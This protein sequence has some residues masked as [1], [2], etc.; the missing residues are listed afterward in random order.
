MPHSV[1]R[2]ALTLSVFAAV[3]TLLFAP[4]VSAASPSQSALSAKIPGLFQFAGDQLQRT[5]QTL[6]NAQY[7][8]TTDA[9]GKWKTTAASGWTSG[10]FPGSLW[11][12]YEQS[13]HP[14]WKT[15]AQTW[16]R[17]LEREKT[18]RTTHDLGFMLFTSFGNGHRL[19]GE[20]RYR[21]VLL[22]A[23]ESLASRHSSAVGAIKS[24]EGKPNEFPVIVDSLMNLELLFWASAHGGKSAWRDLA[25]Q[26]A[27]KVQRDHVRP[28][29]S[30]VH[31]VTYNPTTGAVVKKSTAQGTS[32]DSTWSRGQAWA[33][34]GFTIVYRETG[35]RSF[36]QAARKTADFFLTNLP[37]DSVPRWDFRAPAGD[38]K[39]SSAAAIAASG[40][41]ELSRLEIDASRRTRYF[42]VAEKI[43]SSLASPAYLAKGTSSRALLL[44][45]TYNKPA[46]DFDTGTIWGDYYLLEALLRYKRLVSKR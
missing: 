32:A 17:N 16:L 42:K 25:I 31:V 22:T 40:L 7:P 43:L 6:R 13:K 18:N 30:T 27:R 23:A 39:D 36:L 45:G 15:R 14:V 2:K 5:A 21:R 44:H 3:S 28:D 38:S 10:F 9:S 41:L 12:L 33:L 46:G 34:H 24:W 20:D 37:S 1:S 4:A 11:L 35:D 26:H 29:G 19:T 8:I